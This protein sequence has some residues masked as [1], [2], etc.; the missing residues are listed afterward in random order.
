MRTAI[1]ITDIYSSLRRVLPLLA[2]QDIESL[3]SFLR[4]APTAFLR[5]CFVPIH[6]ALQLL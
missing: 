2:A 1:S 5:L 3:S 6:L 4:P